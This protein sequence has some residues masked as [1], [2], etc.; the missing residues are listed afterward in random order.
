MQTAAAAYAVL[1]LSDRRSCGGESNLETGV[2]SFRQGGPIGAEVIVPLD[3]FDFRLRIPS[4]HTH[5][6]LCDFLA[7]Q[8]QPSLQSLK[9]KLSITMM[10]QRATL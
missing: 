9:A 7:R 3:T 2:R 10:R 1:G 5:C 8:C 6:T 4:E